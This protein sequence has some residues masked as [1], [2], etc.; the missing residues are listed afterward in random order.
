MADNIFCCGSAKPYKPR[1]LDHE[2]KF[3]AF[4][5]WA[6]RQKASS[7]V[8]PGFPK[9][10]VPYAVQLVRQINYGPQESIR[11]FIPVGDSDFSELTEDAL[12]RG[13]LEK[14][15]TY[16][17]F[18]CNLHNKFFEVNLYQKS[19]R[20]AHHWRANLARPSRDIDLAYRQEQTYSESQ[21]AATADH[22]DASGDAPCNSVIR[23][24]DPSPL[25]E[26]V[27]NT[28]R[29]RPE[30]LNMENLKEILRFLLAEVEPK[31]RPSG[32]VTLMCLE[33]VNT[34]LGLDLDLGSRWDVEMTVDNVVNFFTDCFTIDG[35]KLAFG[36][37]D[38]LSALVEH[39]MMCV[40]EHKVQLS[41]VSTKLHYIVKKVLDENHE[42]P[43][44]KM[45]GN[46]ILEVLRSGPTKK[47]VEHCRHRDR[48]LLGKPAE[49]SAAT[50]SP[51]FTVAQ[52]LRNM[53]IDG[54]QDDQNWEGDEP[55]RSLPSDTHDD[56]EYEHDYHDYDSDEN[57][58]AKD[59]AACDKECGY[60]GHCDY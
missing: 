25:L 15:N 59:Y 13:N 47:L 57:E 14:L 26:E 30:S 2:S 32:L 7:I 46:G 35:S 43:W 22:T 51:A 42:K 55:S 10:N 33:R 21:T 5:D 9:S 48:K 6:H 36:D 45:H 3:T 49:H 19:P 17:N 31:P 39:A 52:S 20:N 12:L 41:T 60:C 54:C 16:K 23:S 1:Q 56:F 44:V 27:S 8:E 34:E 29:F 28:E 11:Y 4:A 40:D 24:S 58:S 37:L 38:T 53:M 50:T 18:K